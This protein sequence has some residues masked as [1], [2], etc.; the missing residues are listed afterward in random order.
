MGS[1]LFPMQK[2]FNLNLWY[3]DVIPNIFN[4]KHDEFANDISNTF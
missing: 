1:S 3:L 2:Y 4:A